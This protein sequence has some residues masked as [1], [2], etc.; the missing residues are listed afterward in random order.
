MTSA[1]D[2]SRALVARIGRRPPRVW[3]SL[4]IL[5]IPL[6]GFVFWMLPAGSFYDSNLTREAGFKHDIVLIADALGPAIRRQEYGEYVGHALPQPI[7][8]AYGIKMALDRA[9]VN[10]LPQSMTVDDAG[11]VTFTIEAWSHSPST[12]GPYGVSNFGDQVTMSTASPSFIYSK[13]SVPLLAGYSI[14]FAS[15]SG[16]ADGPIPL[17]ILLPGVGGDTAINPKASEIWISPRMVNSIE[18]LSA[19]AQ[20]DPRQASGSLWRM[21]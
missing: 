2:R 8:N 21:L 19:A 18:H 6:A 5:L 11:N 17:S 20:G 1:R 10:V 13:Y 15:S 12:S 3:G 16:G 7:W 14:T 4:Y 9:T